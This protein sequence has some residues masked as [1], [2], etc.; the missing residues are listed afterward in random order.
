MK[1]HFIS[2]INHKGINHK[3]DWVTVA[4]LILCR[5]LDQSQHQLC[6]STYCLHSLSILQGISSGINWLKNLGQELL[7]SN[8]Y[9]TDEEM[10]ISSGSC[11]C[12]LF[13]ANNFDFSCPFN[14]A[15]FGISG[16]YYI[17]QTVLH[18][19]WCEVSRRYVFLW[20]IHFH[21]HTS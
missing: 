10:G 5:G 12:Y 11:Q 19:W 9:S 18:V 1:Y 17:H 6:P 8:I 16:E 7:S 3:R 20:T 4:F 2:L 21:S 15:P 13:V 14:P